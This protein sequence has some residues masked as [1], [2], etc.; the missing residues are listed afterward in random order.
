[1]L[2]LYKVITNILYPFLI[3]YMYFR[4]L[5]KKE[6][7]ERFKEKI[8]PTHFNINKTEKLNCVGFML[9]VLEN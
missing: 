9:L 4:K 7:S 2:F 8:Y 3:L 5:I 6:H 1:M